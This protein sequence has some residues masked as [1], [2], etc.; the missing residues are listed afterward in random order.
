MQEFEEMTHL[1]ESCYEKAYGLPSCR[2]IYYESGSD[3]AIIIYQLTW[4][5]GTHVAMKAEPAE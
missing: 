5:T 2:M 3:S 1:V 4:R